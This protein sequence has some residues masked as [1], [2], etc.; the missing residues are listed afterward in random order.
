MA[1]SLNELPDATADFACAQTPAQP[2][3]GRS[4][5]R[6]KAG[7]SSD[8]RSPLQ[9]G[10]SA[11]LLG[12][13]R[14]RA[15]RIVAPGWMASPGTADVTVAPGPWAVDGVG[16]PGSGAA[17]AAG[18]APGVGVAVGAGMPVKRG[19]AG[20]AAPG[21][22]SCGGVTGVTAHATSTPRI[23]ALSVRPR[24]AT[25]RARIQPGHRIDMWI[26]L[27]EALAALVVLLLI[28][29]WT[30]FHGRSRGERRRDADD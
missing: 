29:W 9:P 15:C 27:L 4:Q 12:T 22:V 3:A 13:Q 2:A 28:V 1:S 19:A 14:E 20:V 21:A 17:V 11:Q 5:P 18:A 7:Q 30:M 10:S 24:T 16:G 8:G 25:M 26:I 23:A 6:S